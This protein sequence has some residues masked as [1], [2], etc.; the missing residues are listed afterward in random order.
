MNI[1]SQENGNDGTPPLNTNGVLL[2]ENKKAL[3][4]FMSYTNKNLKKYT[5]SKSETLFIKYIKIVCP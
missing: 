5:F 4:S 1:L 2:T 3:I